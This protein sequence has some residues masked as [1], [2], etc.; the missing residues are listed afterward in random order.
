MTPKEATENK[1]WRRLQP[2]TFITCSE[3][4][5]SNYTSP[6]KHTYTHEGPQWH[7]QQNKYQQHASFAH[8]T[9]KIGPSRSLFDYEKKVNRTRSYNLCAPI[10]RG[11]ERPENNTRKVKRAVGVHLFTFVLVVD[12]TL[13]CDKYLRKTKS[14]WVPKGLCSRL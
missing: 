11:S 9:I 6:K 8:D 5:S 13:C 3:S 2:E 7:N 1:S 12:S 14:G 10:I 4:V